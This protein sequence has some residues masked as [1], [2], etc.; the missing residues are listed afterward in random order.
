M[1]RTLDPQTVAIPDLGGNNL[2]DSLT[3]IIANPRAALLVLNPGI[4]E[5]VRLDGDARLSTD[6]ELLASWDGLLRRPKLAVVLTI[7]SV[8]IHCAKAF[9]RS[10]LWRPETWATDVPDACVLFDEHTGAGI[11][12]AEMREFLEEDYRVTLAD[13][14]PI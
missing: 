9:R 2:V 11:D 1:V 13:E 14:R 4:D 8:F 12:V 10:G 6:P 3:N 5:T 7:E